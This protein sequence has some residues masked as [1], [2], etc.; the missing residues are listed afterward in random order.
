MPHSKHPGFE[1]FR[2]EFG[3]LSVDRLYVFPKFVQLETVSG[4]NARCTMCSVASWVRSKPVM[5]DTLFA[6]I[7]GEL[8][9]HA[10]WIEQVTVHMGDEPLLDR[11][12]EERIAALKDAGM[13]SVNF[14]TNASLMSEDR[15]RSMLA[16]GVDSIDFSIDGTT[17]K[18]FETIRAN[19]KFN[20]VRNNVLRF[21]ALRD[22]LEKRVQI[23]LRMVI[24][25]QN[26]HEFDDF[27][28]FWRGRLRSTDF[29]LGR[30][31]NWWKGWEKDLAGV[32]S[33]YLWAERESIEINK[34]PCIAPF[35]SLVV[36]SDGRVPLCCLDYNAD[37]SMG[38]LN[39]STIEEVWRGAKFQNVRHCHLS[40]GRQSMDVCR[41]CHTFVSDSGFDY[42]GLLDDRSSPR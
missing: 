35:S 6:R 41:D 21:I 20:E 26:A 19:L 13:R 12:L 17:A 8:R 22:Q 2:N 32:R 10:D 7:L 28:Q 23:R 1:D 29:V 38:D 34:L 5:S 3:V 37:V 14:T 16:S 15:A 25:R 39:Q 42:H 4:C 30:I 24:Q 33:A 9:E 11:R 27:V 36:L 18:T 31:L 40:M